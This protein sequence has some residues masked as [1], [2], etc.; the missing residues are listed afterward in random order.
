MHDLCRIFT[1]RP[2]TL[3]G[4]MVNVAVRGLYVDT[5]AHGLRWHAWRE[6]Q[7]TALENQLKTI[8]ILT[9]LSESLHL[10]VVS[11]CENLQSLPP[12]RLYRMF[13]GDPAHPN[14][15]SNLKAR[16]LPRGWIYQNMV[17]TARRAPA[18]DTWID[19]VKRTLFPRQ[20]DAGQPTLSPSCPYTFIA[21]AFVPNIS[22][23][24]QRAALSQTK[25][26]QAIIA[27]ALERY[28]L[29][30]GDYPADLNAL[31][32]PY[33]SEIPVDVIGGQPPHYSRATNGAFLLY[34]IGWSERD[35]GGTPA[36]SSAEGDWVWPE[37]NML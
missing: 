16:L 3:V 34:S 31:V 30:Q 29:A 22:K 20:V 18:V 32:P 9:P 11:G 4:A 25:V 10:E 26:H 24:C 19:P 5:I 8:N 17:V 12:E 23:A 21:A 13:F 27:C 1:N 35:G 7:L 36:T 2:I 6:P 14:W 15:W 37:L 33:L 28:R